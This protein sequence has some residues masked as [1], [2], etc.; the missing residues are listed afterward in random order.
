MTPNPVSIDETAT[1][2]EAMALL[3]DRGLHAAPVI[4]EAGHPIGVLTNTD[5]LVHL[6]ESAAQRPAAA[7]P[8][9]VGDIMTPVVF[10]V[11]PQA[12]PAQV[13]K[14]MLDLRV[15][16]LF[17]VDP[18]GVLIGV[19]SAMDLLRQLQEAVSPEIVRD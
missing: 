18:S 9:L 4:D 16:T 14:E 11:L 7:E 6:R 13:I 8:S 1:I 10:S 19:I 5:I 3:L 12:P 15:H 17:V 2:P